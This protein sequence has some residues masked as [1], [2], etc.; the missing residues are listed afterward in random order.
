MS[1]RR[2]SHAASVDMNRLS[3]LDRL[4]LAQAVWE[5]G[6]EWTAIAKILSKHP[7]LLHPKSFF[8]AQ[9]SMAVVVVI[10]TDEAQFLVASVMRSNVQLSYK[11][12]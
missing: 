11:G 5:I 4:I 3:K 12:S 7:L 1:T 2:R 9:V 6:T 10:S 8:T